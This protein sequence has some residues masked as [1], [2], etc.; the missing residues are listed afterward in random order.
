MLPW[1][2]EHLL[3]TEQRLGAEYWPVGFAKNRATLEVII[4]YMRE[5]GLTKAAL[6]PESL[7]S[8]ADILAT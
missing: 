8:G 4:R 5:D 7:F 2:L 1:L 6:A 3:D